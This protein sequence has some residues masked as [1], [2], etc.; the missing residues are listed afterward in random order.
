MSKVQRDIDRIQ[1]DSKQVQK[2]ARKYKDARNVREAHK[3]SQEMAKLSKQI[4]EATR[5]QNQLNKYEKK[6]RRTG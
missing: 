2:L 1:Q 6:I 5:I 4:E 3:I